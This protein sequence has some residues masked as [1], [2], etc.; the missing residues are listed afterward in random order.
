V[1]NSRCPDVS[2]ITLTWNSE[3]YIKKC[4]TSYANS[5]STQGICAEFIVIDNGSADSTTKI[6]EKDVAHLL[7]D[8]CTLNFI[9]L[10][11]NMG[12]TMPRNIGISKSHAPV[13]IIC[14]SDTEYTQGNWTEIFEL[15]KHNKAVG[16]V[17]PCLCYHDG[18]IQPS[19]KKFPVIT[20]KLRKLSKIF[21]GINLVDR[22]FYSTFPWQEPTF[23]ECAISACWILSLN[24][25]TK[26]G[27]LDENIFYSPEDL[28]YCSRIWK[29]GKKILYY[30]HLKLIHHTQQI[31]HKKPFSIQSLSHLKGLL[32]YFLKHRYLFSRRTINI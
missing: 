14:D 3:K 10:G 11:K 16:I 30:P 19:V 23:A 25:I 18:L 6:I 32:Y 5:F 15:V 24:T 20:D 12:T 8:C 26:V 4:L 31:S 17:A 7:P 27:L 2:I 28:D 21:F 22:D 1:E 29:N 9:K 13:I